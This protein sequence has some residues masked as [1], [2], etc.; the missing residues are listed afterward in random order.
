L[1][2]LEDP[3]EVI[4]VDSAS[5][6]PIAELPAR[7]TAGMASVTYVREDRRGLS[8][9]RNRGLAETTAPIVAFLDDDA[10][11]HPDWARRILAPFEANDRVGCVGGACM[12]R[13]AEGARRPHWLSD[14]LL[15]FAGITVFQGPARAA[16]SSAEWPFGANIAFRVQALPSAAPFPEHLG[17][18]GTTLLSGEEYAVV[19]SMRAAGWIIWLEPGAVVRHTVTAERC[20]SGYYW[21]RLWWAGVSRARST[22]TSIRLGLRLVVA[23]PIR[24]T[25]FAATRDRVHLYRAAETAGYLSERMRLRRRPA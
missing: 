11:P 20:Q 4:V 10:A 1:V 5:E 17:R 15:Q 19:E 24:L 22:D 6:P 9:A 14:R 8:L 25:L 2:A 13:F 21:R 12:A 23:A 3:V 7:G 16:R 18:T